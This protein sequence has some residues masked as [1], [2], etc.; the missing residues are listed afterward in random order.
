MAL[1]ESNPRV[2][3]IGYAKW[4]CPVAVVG[5]YATI[6]VQSLA[7]F[8]GWVQYLGGFRQAIPNAGFLFDCGVIFSAAPT[9]IPG[10]LI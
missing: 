4:I 7:Q 8:G 5:L 6:Y 9:I 2:P 10:A 3:W 1:E